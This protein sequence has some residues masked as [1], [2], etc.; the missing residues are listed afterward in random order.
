[1]D[2]KGY[3]RV[4]RLIREIL[5]NERSIERWRKENEKYLEE[6][7]ELLGRPVT[8]EEVLNIKE[9]D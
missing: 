6:L 5:S 3:D 7:T 2:L 4:G 9:E 8:I 1:M